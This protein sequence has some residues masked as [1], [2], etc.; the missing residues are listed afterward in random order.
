LHGQVLR[1][2]KINWYMA[3]DS[4]GGKVADRLVVPQHKL[5]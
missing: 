5:G 3:Y 2:H 1:A 4:E